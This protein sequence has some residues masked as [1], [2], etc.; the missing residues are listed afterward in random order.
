MEETID[1]AALIARLRH[2]I[3]RLE[4]EVKAEERCDRSYG[5]RSSGLS[6]QIEGLQLALA[7]AR[8]KKSLEIPAK[9]PH[10][11]KWILVPP[12]DDYCEGCD[13]YR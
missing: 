1:R 11:H 3:T 2:E 8:G 4:E 5:L 13:S 10:R 9:K 12:G 6:G 7:F